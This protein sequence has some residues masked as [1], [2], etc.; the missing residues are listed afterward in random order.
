[1]SWRRGGA[2]GRAEDENDVLEL[3]VHGVASTPPAAML[4]VRPEQVEQV[5]GDDLGSFWTAPAAA[6]ERT[7]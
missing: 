5:D 2:P 6:A 4:D 7:A 3:R 1:M